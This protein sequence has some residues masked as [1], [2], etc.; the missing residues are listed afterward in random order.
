MTTQTKLRAALRA[1]FKSPREALRALGLDADLL[2]APAPTNNAHDPLKELRLDLEKLIGEIGMPE[3]S[4]SKILSLLDEHIPEGRVADD[5]PNRDKVRALAGHDEEHDDEDD[6]DARI[7]KVRTMLQKHGLTA[8]E[9][10]Q[11]I[12]I[13]TGASTAKDKLPVNALHGGLGGYLSGEERH[14]GTF[15]HDSIEQ[16]FDCGRIIGE[17]TRQEDHDRHPAMDTP[18]AEFHRM[19]PGIELIG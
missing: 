14:R 8:S 11:A 16:L 9:I 1:R 12:R 13:A 5:D 7:A 10:D 3:G 2:G 4:I 19:F 6:D 17:R 18:A 15:A